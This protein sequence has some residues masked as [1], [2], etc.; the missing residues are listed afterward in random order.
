MSTTNL[1]PNTIVP[2]SGTY[3]CFACQFKRDALTTLTKQSGVS[4]SE[5]KGAL[6][7]HGYGLNKPTTR[8]RFNTGERFDQCPVCKEATGWSLDMQEAVR[9]SAP[10]KL[11]EKKKE[12]LM[13][14]PPVPG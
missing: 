2:T 10:L 14:C 9:P 3:Y 8:K 6:N 13:E 1:R 4:V 11:A 12:L 5:L 7:A